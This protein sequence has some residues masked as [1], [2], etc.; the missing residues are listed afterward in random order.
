MRVLLEDGFSIEKGTG[1]GRYTQNLA[2]ELEKRKDVILLSPVASPTLVKVRPVSFRRILYTAWLETGFQSRAA[3]LGPD[4]IHYTNHLVPRARKSNAKYVVTIHDLTAWRLPD[5]LPPLYGRYVRRAISQAVKMA[6]LVLCP[7][8]SIKKE[9]I[10]HFSLGHGKVRTAWN[11]DSHLPEVPAQ[12]QEELYRQL[13]K[14]L[15]LRKPFLLF[16]GTLEHRKNVTTLIEAFGG[17]GDAHDLQLAIVGRPGYKF[18]EIREALDRQACR[19]RY[20]LTGFLSDEELAVLYQLAEVFVYPS[21][22]EGFGIPL[23]EAMGFGLPVV[24]SRIPSTEEVAQQTAL[25]YENPLDARALAKTI[26]HLITHPELKEMLAGGAKKRAAVFTM[27]E[28]MKQ[29]LDAYRYVL[30]LKG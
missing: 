27:D 20:I 11:M 5:S 28:I 25:Y 24:A 7:S 10:E 19:E 1:I 17:I 16:V 21:L 2:S 8:A 9:V 26:E 30:G 29:Y 3:R 23:V 12:R 15:G 22:Y 14:R 6:D 18:P 13:G 4:I